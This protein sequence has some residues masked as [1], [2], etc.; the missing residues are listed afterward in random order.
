[1]TGMRRGG[2]RGSR[3]TPTGGAASIWPP[4][5]IGERDATTQLEYI[6]PDDGNRGRPNPGAPAAAASRWRR[7]Q[8][9][10]RDRFRRPPAA[11]LH[12]LRTGGA[13]L[14]R[15][16]VVSQAGG[17][18]AER[19][20]EL[21][22]STTPTSEFF[23]DFGTYDVALTVPQKLRRRRPPAW[24]PASATTRDGTRTIAGARRDGARLRLDRRSALPGRR[25][26]RS[27]TY[28]SACS[29][30]PDHLRQADRYLDA[31]RAPWRAT[32]PGSARI[33]TRS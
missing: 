6:R 16:A 14:L 29:M 5:R 30:Q 8:R 18:F 9:R 20:V 13:V 17:V 27:A 31:L 25:A 4:M 10:G 22:T 3:A 12:A 28:A 1:M 2:A 24:S 26:G 33:R 15:G 21:L 11:P 23:A 19:R 32:R 7:R